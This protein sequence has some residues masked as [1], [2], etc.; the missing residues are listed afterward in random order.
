MKPTRAASVQE[1]RFERGMPS[2]AYAATLYH[3]GWIIPQII[4]NHCED[5]ELYLIWKL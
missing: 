2:A 5:Y 3:E 4:H 1:D